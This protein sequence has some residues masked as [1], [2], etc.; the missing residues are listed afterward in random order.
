MQAARGP[1]VWRGAD[2][3]ARDWVVPIAAEE[4]DELARA[5]SPWVG[6]SLDELTPDQFAI[7]RI[8]PKLA[9]AA[10]TLRHGTG[11][12]MFRG[13]PAERLSQELIEVIYW[14]IG[15]HLG[16]GVSQSSAGDRL[17]HVFD[18]GTGEKERYYTR[19]GGHG[20][21]PPRPAAMVFHD[22][23]DQAGGGVRPVERH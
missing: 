23:V 22:R 12:V 15:L 14:G 21:W 13:L 10:H 3:D 16:V 18:R 19:G 9:T 1:A 2:Q 8:L 4:S 5:A 11:F 20:Q 7:P 17:G 6:R